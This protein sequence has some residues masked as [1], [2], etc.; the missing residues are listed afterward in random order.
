MIGYIV[1]AGLIIICALKWL[2]YY[3]SS[4][5]LLWYLQKKGYPFPNESEMKEG[6]RFVVEHT[7][8]DLKCFFGCKS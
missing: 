1:L 8:K 7:L 4:A 5:S 2:T 3:I 6:S